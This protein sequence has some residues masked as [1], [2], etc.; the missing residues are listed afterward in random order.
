[1]V[2]TTCECTYIKCLHVS[3]GGPHAQWDNRRAVSSALLDW[4]TREEQRC[5]M[6]IKSL[7]LS[8]D[9]LPQMHIDEKE[10]MAQ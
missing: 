4:L 3:W 5:N 2:I 10:H 1:M 9:D 8:G 6:V 7:M